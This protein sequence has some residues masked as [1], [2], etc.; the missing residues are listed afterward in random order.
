[1]I[2]TMI[3]LLVRR[4]FFLSHATFPNS[5]IRARFMRRCYLEKNTKGFVDGDVRF[6]ALLSLFSIRRYSWIEAARTDIIRTLTKDWFHRLTCN[7]IA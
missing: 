6:A 2:I 4:K 7:L 3:S 5:G 1:M